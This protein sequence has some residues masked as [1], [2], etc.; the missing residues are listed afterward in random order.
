MPC[1]ETHLCAR[2]LN[3]VMHHVIEWQTT[4][5][6]FS[7]MESTCKCLLEGGLSMVPD[8]SSLAL[9]DVL[10]LFNSILDALQLMREQRS[11][12]VHLSV[13]FTDECH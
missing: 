7:E 12:N 10:S 3:V 6:Y 2:A 1:K 4:A 9:L 5:R 11:T 13:M 8:L